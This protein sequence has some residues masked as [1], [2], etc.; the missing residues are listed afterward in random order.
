MDSCPSLYFR[1]KSD[2]KFKLKSALRS[3]QE[4]NKNFLRD[5]LKFLLLSCLLSNR[6]E[7]IEMFFLTSVVIYHYS[8]TLAGSTEHF[9]NDGFRS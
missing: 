5:L 7:S 2:F 8:V 4:S 1:P 9:T 3:V 6:S